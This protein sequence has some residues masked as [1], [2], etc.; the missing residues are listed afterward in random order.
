MNS[1]LIFVRG[2]RLIDLLFRE[3]RLQLTTRRLKPQ[4]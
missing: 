1:F 3:S 2:G 4:H